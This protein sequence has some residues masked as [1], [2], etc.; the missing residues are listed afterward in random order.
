MF[1]NL[2]EDVVAESS[3]EEPGD[4][5]GKE[6]LFRNGINIEEDGDNESVEWETKEVHDSRARPFRNN[7]PTKSTGRR[8]VKATGNFKQ[9]KGSDQIPPVVGPEGSRES[10]CSGEKSQPHGGMRGVPLSKSQRKER[11][12]EHDTNHKDGKDLAKG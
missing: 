4:E 7:F 8:K 6:S 9:E 11:G 1:G 10:S 3:S 2:D 12:A 5:N